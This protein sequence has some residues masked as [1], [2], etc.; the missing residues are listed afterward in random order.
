M[1]A[2]DTSFPINTFNA[3]WQSRNG[4]I[5]NNRLFLWKCAVPHIISGESIAA[6]ILH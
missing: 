2:S 6:K 1:Q 4:A 5:L 3:I